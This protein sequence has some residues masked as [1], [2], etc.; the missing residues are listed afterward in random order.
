MRS[1]ACDITAYAR[2]RYAGIA[3]VSYHTVRELE[4][5]SD[6][7]VTAY[8]AKGD[9]GR[10]EGSSI[11]VRK[12][13]PWTYRIGRSF[14]IAHSLCHRQLAVEAQ[15]KVYTVY[16]AWSFRPNEYQS[17]E[18]QEKLGERMRRD[19]DESHLVL[20]I[21]EWTRSELIQLGVVDPEYCYALPIGIAVP[22]KEEMEAARPVVPVQGLKQFALYVG[23]LEN[24]K[25]LPHIIEAVR[26]FNELGLVLVGEPG[27]GYDEGVKDM[28]AS[29]PQER[30]VALS[31]IGD[32]E[33]LW[34]YQHA[35]VTM[36]P[37][38][39][40]GFGLPML[41]AMAAGSP[42]ITSDRSGCAEIARGAAFMVDPA[43]P[44]QSRRAI[45]QIREDA[46]FRN[47]LIGDG[48][49]RAAEY[50]WTRYGKSLRECYDRL[51]AE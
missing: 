12:H 39:E 7:A 45:E 48:K 9:P 4:K 5:F 40:E 28:L 36:L 24:R 37:S 17:P 27:Y 41:E 22:T 46:K 50:T 30:L 13:R 16:D 3:R 31:R 38:W 51:T 15:Y 35:L 42:V 10:F 20:T 26:P 19:L 11:A 29:F 8:Y 44:E 34:L 25:N 33:L 18:F 47:Q 49:R 2:N 43:E 1:V 32:S 6:L 23:R 21:S 14:D